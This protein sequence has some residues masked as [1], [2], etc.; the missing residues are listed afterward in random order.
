VLWIDDASGPPRVRALTAS[1]PDTRLELGP[2]GPVSPERNRVLALKVEEL[3]EHEL[4]EPKR[5]AAPNA[6]ASAPRRVRTRAFVEL[7]VRAWQGGRPSQLV[8]GPA[9]TMGPRWEWPGGV[10]E[11]HGSFVFD[12]E[13]H[14]KTPAGQVDA[15]STF[16]GLGARALWRLPPFALGPYLEA[17]VDVLR[18]RGATSDKRHGQSE[19]LSPTAALGCDLRLR[20]TPHF[21][22]RASAGPQV[23]FVHERLQLQGKQVLDVGALHATGTLSG[24]FVFP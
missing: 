2:L 6:S 16:V 10:L 13:L 22:L 9:L 8:T 17:G 21:E 7:G 5:D 18:A 23:L 3:L 20:F 1:A 11:A 24:L 19:L 14:A 12:G 15:D 4:A